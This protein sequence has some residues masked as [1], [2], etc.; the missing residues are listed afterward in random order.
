MSIVIIN[1]LKLQNSKLITL[2]NVV[3]NNFEHL[4]QTPE[5]RHTKEEIYK[6]LKSD[7]AQVFLYLINGKIAGYL[8]GEITN[9]NDGRTIFYI[10]YIF[11]AKQFRNTG[12]ASELIKL[13]EKT[14]NNHSLNALALTCDTNNKILY[15]WYLKMGFMPDLI[16]RNYSRHEILSK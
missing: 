5:L 14:V 12:I 2:T 3:Y 8:I 15:N 10:S 6:L 9:L 13:A 7:V 1:T 11:T 16:L 4:H